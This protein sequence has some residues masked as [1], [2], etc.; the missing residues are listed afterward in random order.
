MKGLLALYLAALAVAC[1]TLGLSI[2]S[3]VQPNWITTTLP[4][5]SPIDLHLTTA[6]GLFEAC[7][8]TSNSHESIVTCRKFPNR[9]RDCGSDDGGWGFCDS[10]ISAGYAHQLS[11]V[12]ALTSLLALALTLFGTAT[13][14]RGFRTE[15][16]RSGWKLFTA[17]M[18][19]Q[20]GCLILST[21]LVAREFGHDAR[22]GVGSKLGHAFILATVAWALNVLVVFS[23]LFVRATGKLRIVPEAAGRED[24]YETI[25]D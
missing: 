4:T 11:L 21:S 25:R 12:F 2:A 5:R 13:A 18:G 23:I 6:Y 17:L 8:T 9:A 24:G 19:L 10:W 7:E 15:R 1:S 14:G 3:L 22:F 20:A 16:L